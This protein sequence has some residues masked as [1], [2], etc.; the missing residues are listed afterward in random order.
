MTLERNIGIP[1]QL[2]INGEAIDVMVESV[3]EHDE[4]KPIYHTRDFRDS[5]GILHTEEVTGVTVPTDPTKKNFVAIEAPV[6]EGYT[7]AFWINSR[8]VGNT[9]PVSLI[10][11]TSQ[12][13]GMFVYFAP[14][15]DIAGIGPVKTTV[16]AV[17]VKSEKA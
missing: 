4:E 17:Y 15:E 5:N 3:N 1:A 2:I 11:S 8:C 13:T 16:T 10:Q 7:F 12:T 14:G 6:V 9:L